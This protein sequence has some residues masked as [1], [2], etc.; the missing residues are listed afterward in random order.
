MEY[1]NYKNNFLYEL[2]QEL[3][4]ETIETIIEIYEHHPSIKLIREH[5]QNKTI[6][7]ISKLL[8]LDKLT[9]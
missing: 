6:T 4:K 2:D 9:K 5:I 3:S 8:V 7:L 1:R